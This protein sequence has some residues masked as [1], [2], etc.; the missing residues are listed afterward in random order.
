MLVG[1]AQYPAVDILSSVS[2]LMSEVMDKEHLDK[3]YEFRKI[4]ADYTKIEDLVNLG[5]YVKGNNQNTDYALEMI[6]DLNGF[7]QQDVE[8]ASSMEEGLNEITK[9]LTYKKIEASP[10]GE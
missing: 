7:L 8:T 3:A 1:P 5:A 6:D 9:L 2:R 4:L 10:P